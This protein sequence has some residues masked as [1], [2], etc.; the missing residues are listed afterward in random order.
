MF[1]LVKKDKDTKARVG[2]IKTA[3]GEINTPNFAPV[4]T[5][6]AVKTL[7]SSELTQ[8]GVEFILS[9]TYHL[10]LKPKEK[11]ITQ[12]GGLYNFMNWQR[13]IITDS[14]GY[15]IFSLSA[16]RK[17]KSDGVE[18][19]SHLDGSRHFLTPES[20][21]GFQQVL[22]SDIMM[23]LDECVHYPATR[24]YTEQSLKLT[25]D[26][27]KRSK[28]FFKSHPSSLGPQ[29]IFGIVQGGTYPDLRRQSAQQLIDIGFD[30]YAIG[31]LSVGEPRD[32]MHEMLNVTAPILPE[33]K[34]RYLMGVGT[35][36]DIF[37]AVENGIDIFDCVI[38]T[39]NGRNG[40]AFTNKGKLTIRNAEYAHDFK[41]VDS[42]CSC[43][44]CKKYT[45]AYLRHLFNI[46][47]ML[48]L[49]LL[50]LHNIYFYVTLMG[51]IRRA[52]LNNEFLK[53]K[54]EVCSCYKV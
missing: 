10:Y 33:D 4:G 43:P 52:I 42:H 2:R 20:I 13:P 53:Y 19:Q 35:P 32:I 47:E 24:D 39:R 9:N 26:W 21:V 36:E 7:S 45:R 49:R 46:E 50:S 15:Q 28:N 29:S 12:A 38:P 51:N 3:H 22:G 41:P 25:T 37:E 44:C 40:T 1:E 48:G 27:A 14:G 54:K 30:G 23:V 5:G 8:A 34:A 6:G 17:I 11:I 31:G 18:F 16:L